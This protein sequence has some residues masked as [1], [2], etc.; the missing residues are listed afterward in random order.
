MSD[1]NEILDK[2]KNLFE[3]EK[4]NKGLSIV[5]KLLESESSFEESS[6]QIMEILTDMGKKNPEIVFPY[7]TKYY[8]SIKISK[9]RMRIISLFNIF[10]QEQIN[11]K[12]E[13]DE[14]N[15]WF[16]LIHTF[17]KSKDQRVLNFALKQVIDIYNKDK[18][19]FIKNYQWLARIIGNEAIYNSEL[20]N[21][22]EIFEFF[23]EMVDIESNFI[24]IILPS[25]KKI[26]KNDQSET[27]IEI[28][29]LIGYLSLYNISKLEDFISKIQKS[30]EIKNLHFRRYVIE[31][32]GRFGYSD[33]EL[34]KSNLSQIIRL[35]FY[36]DLIPEI[37]K[38]LA[39]HIQDYTAEIL[40]EIRTIFNEKKF[41]TSIISLIS[42]LIKTSS[43]KVNERFIDSLLKI[44]N[45]NIDIVKK[46]NEI[47]YSL[48]DPHEFIR[49]CPLCF[50][51]NAATSRFCNE[52]GF[53]LTLA[54]GIPFKPEEIVKRMDIL[55][56]GVKEEET[57]EVELEEQK[58]DIEIE[59]IQRM[60]K[61]STRI[62]LEMMRHA[63]N[64]DLKTFNGKIFKWAEDF[65]LTIDGDYL[66]I[67]KETISDFIDELD[68]QFKTWEYKEKK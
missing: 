35:S 49:F 40:N 2:A 53:L 60:I 42:E 7:I 17:K 66:I 43:N 23:K 16:L 51:K 65:G 55:G 1:V 4:I 62:K 38:V 6:S 45:K 3:E 29:K 5:L 57:K 36:S 46:L 26:Y 12:G 44:E 52:D 33:F 58:E 10:I 67:N 20:D 39:L 54:N 50:S 8:K 61:V 22:K 30:L 48:K 34:L 13:I 27:D 63:L 64:M 37:S 32:I 59:E 21:L 25:I 28:I 14:V 68:R 47:R 19:D 18:E 9:I 56:K 11:T 24:G 15:P 41:R 31:A